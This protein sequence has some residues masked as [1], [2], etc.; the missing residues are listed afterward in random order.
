MM[1]D[2]KIRIFILSLISGIVFT[3]A[4]HIPTSYVSCRRRNYKSVTTSSSSPLGSAVVLNLVPLRDFHQDD[5]SSSS[6]ATKVTF[7]LESDS[8]RT[9]I[10]ENGELRSDNNNDDDDDDDDE[11][12]P[13]VLCV[14]EEDDLPA[15]SKMII[16]SFGS[17]AIVFSTGDL[18]PLEQALVQPG[19]NLLNAYSGAVAYAEV[20]SGKSKHT[21]HFIM[22]PFT[23]TYISS[24]LL[25]LL[26]FHFT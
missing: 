22:L 20:L 4:F 23:T 25:L 15:I 11:S 19:V 3:S 2:S 16:E 5:T 17:D 1:I 6:P 7:L 18:S 9:C 8:Y 24:L 12:N 13:F 26:S 21:S 10:D 14:A